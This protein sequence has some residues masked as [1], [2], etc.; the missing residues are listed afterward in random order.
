MQL[1]AGDVFIWDKF[2]Y[3]RDVG[4]EEKPRWFIHCGRTSI[5]DPTK[6]VLLITTTTQKEHYD[7]TGRR[8]SHDIMRITK[9]T[10]GFQ[11]NCTVDLNMNFYTDITESDFQHCE[12]DLKKEGEL[13]V[14]RVRQL[15]NLVSKNNTISGKIKSDI[16]NSFSRDRNIS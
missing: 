16:R 8:H 5:I 4:S 12:S 6:F 14:D 11:E 9:G 7:S 3:V 2:P 15:L 10:A 1:K 13:P